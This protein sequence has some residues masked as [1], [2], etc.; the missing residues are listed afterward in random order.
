MA[1][2]NPQKKAAASAK[3]KSSSAKHHVNVGSPNSPGAGGTAK[4]AVLTILNKAAALK[5]ALGQDS[6]ERKKLPALTGIHGKSTIAN[7]L[8]KLKNEGWML[9]TP[10]SVTITGSGMNAADPTAVGTI[11]E[12]IPTTNAAYHKSVKEQYKL[13]PK[14]IELFDCIQDGKVYE[15]EK[16]AEKIGMKMNSTFANLMT[17]LKKHGVIEYDT[18]TVRLTDAMMPFEHRAE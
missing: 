11:M 9:V 12:D 18:K 6:L 4:G 14:A 10:D 5:T 15:K 17:S 13:K 7:A 3:K 16:V 8:T 2:A 1:K